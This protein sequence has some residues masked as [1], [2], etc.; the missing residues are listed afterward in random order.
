M[1]VRLKL[2]RSSFLALAFSS[3]VFLASAAAHAAMPEIVEPQLGERILSY[4]SW[5][6]DVFRLQLA[7]IE[8]GY[9]LAADGHF[10]SATRR[11]VTAFQIDHGLKPDGIVGPETL[12]ALLSASS[13]PAVRYVVRPGDSLWSIARDFGVTMEELIRLNNLPD[14]PLQVGEEL[15][16]PARP[17]YTVRPGDTLW[18]IA[19]RFRTTVDELVRLNN[20]A[21][22]SLIRVGT[23]LRLPAD[24]MLPG[25]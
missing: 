23:E 11:V 1:G 9:D 13:R 7:L 8:A 10:G 22:P 25:L 17:V 21:N 14:R 15:I 4:G 19:I 6:A 24:T 12:E 18:E 3:L 2:G 5:G 16:V 20:I